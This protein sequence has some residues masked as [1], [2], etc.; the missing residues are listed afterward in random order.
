[1][2]RSW[3]ILCVG[4]TIST[5]VVFSF[6]SDFKIS[7]LYPH[8]AEAERDFTHYLSSLLL[9][10]ESVNNMSVNNNLGFNITYIWNDTEGS[11]TQSLR[12]MSE[13]WKDGTDAFIGPGLR[14]CSFAARMAAAWNIPLLSYVSLFSMSVCYTLID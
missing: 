12:I 6:T 4:L 8:S 3:R 2:E 13:R 10:V 14:T 1:M 5:L 7:L 11:G 9:A